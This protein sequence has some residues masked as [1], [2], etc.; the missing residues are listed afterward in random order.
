MNSEFIVE[1]DDAQEAAAQLRDWRPEPEPILLLPLYPNR[2]LNYSNAHLSREVGT[3]PKNIVLKIIG[4]SE[5]GHPRSV[6]RLR[7][8]ASDAISSNQLELRTV[9]NHPT[10]PR[11]R[12]GPKLQDHERF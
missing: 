1:R 2:I 7:C 10:A 11:G 12:I 6:S 3:S 5:L 4:K 8:D 9:T